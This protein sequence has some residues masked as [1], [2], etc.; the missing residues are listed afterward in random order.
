MKRASCLATAVALLT[1]CAAAAQTTGPAQ[2]TPGNGATQ[3]IGAPVASTPAE[4]ADNGSDAQPTG[5]RDIVVTAQRRSENLQ[6][7][8]IAISVATADQLQASGI[9]SLQNLKLAAPS[10]QIANSAGQ[11]FPFIRG[12]GTRA[13]APGIEAPIAV[14]VDGVYFASTASTAFSFN[15]IERIEVLRGPQGTLF[16]RNATGGLIQVVTRDPSSV[17][18]G[19]G[20][21]G[22]GSYGTLRGNLYLTGGIAGGVNADI[23][24]TAQTMSDGY[25]T[26]R[27]NGEDVGRIYHDI[28]VRSKWKVELGPRT[29]ARLIVDYSDNDS[30]TFAA[31]ARNGTSVPAIFGT[32]IN[33]DYDVS[34]EVQPTLRTQSG[35]VSLRVDHDLGA[36]KLASISAYRQLDY[37]QAFDNDYTATPGQVN[38]V[39]ERDRQFSQEVQILSGTGSSFQWVVGGYYFWAD[40]AY[41]PLRAAFFGPLQ[42]VTPAG[43]LREQLAT[44]A[45]GTNSYAGY[46]QATVQVTSAL[47]LTGGLRYTSER[48]TLN[49]P[50]TLSYLSTP[51]TTTVAD[52]A[53]TFR[54]LTFR[55]ALD[56]AVSSDVLAYASF[57]RGFKSGGFNPA[58]LALGAFRPETLDAYEVGVKST[59]FDRH[60]RLNVAGFRYIYTDLQVSRNVGGVTGIVNGGKAEMYGLDLDAQVQVTPRFD[61]RAAYNYLHAQY[62]S[63]PGAPFAV[64]VATG[65]YRTI[66]GDAAGERTA[67]SPRHSGSLSFNYSLPLGTRSIVFSGTG[68]VSSPFYF[69]P[70]NV[71]R[72][73]SFVTLAG[74]VKWNLSDNLAASVWVNNLT[75][76]RVLQNGNITNGVY[77]SAFEPPRTYGVTLG[78]KF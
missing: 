59:L 38:Y 68:Y 67:L 60:L 66:I 17:F 50:V 74:S 69:E 78:A 36:V 7:V 21:I 16:G 45:Q 5:I 61:I 22:Y 52:A 37:D 9:S 10:V 54:K 65:G 42:R 23:A 51:S 27:F 34:Q 70:D 75:D 18:S 41:R 6:K 26:N 3:A 76:A 32:N 31:T 48:R 11:V 73:G 35:G 62:T 13:L 43:T 72:Q 63:F 24:V 4:A 12:V 28:G 58:V 19:E 71:I 39:T 64:P 1:P 49:G 56:Y 2:T 15:N 77:R 30:N 44:T 47:R 33:A 14:Y 46:G 20:S 57:N 40:A 25:G 55:A 29:Q 53:A 8:P